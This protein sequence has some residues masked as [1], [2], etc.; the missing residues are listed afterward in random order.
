MS[1]PRPR[2]TP[3]QV[4]GIALNRGLPGLMRGARPGLAPVPQQ[5]DRGYRPAGPAVDSPSGLG[6]NRSQ[7]LYSTTMTFTLP[8]AGAGDLYVLSYA[9]RGPALVVPSGWTLQSALAIREDGANGFLNV[10]TKVASGSDT[11]VVLATDGNTRWRNALCQ[12]VLQ[13]VVQSV[14]GTKRQDGG[15]SFTTDALSGFDAGWWAMHIGVASWPTTGDAWSWTLT[16]DAGPAGE[17][18]STAMGHQVITTGAVDAVPLTAATTRDWGWV[19]LIL[20]GS[21]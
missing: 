8:A 2:P 11:S 15:T 3:L 14:G 17:S 18:S 7:V 1:T 9:A 12:V 5:E 20:A 21:P 13:A 19:C 16:T 6:A 4:A 10:I